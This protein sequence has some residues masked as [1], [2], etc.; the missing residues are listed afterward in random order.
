MTTVSNIFDGKKLLTI[1]DED[2]LRRSIE[3]F[4]EDMGFEVFGANNGRVGV[5]VFEQEHPDIVLVDLRMPEMGGLEVISFIMKISPLTPIIVVS[6]TGILDDAL[7]AIRAGAYDYVTKPVTDLK[8][9]E[10][11]VRKALEKTALAE[12]NRKYKEHLEE[13]VEKR[14]AELYHAQK[15]EAIGTLAGGIAHDFNNILSGVI[16]Y[17]ELAI[18]KSKEDEVVEFMH[19]IKK[20]LH[21]AKELVRQILTFS[22]KGE[23]EL[24]PL[25]IG[26]IV[27]E[28]IKLIHS[29]IPSSIS[30]KQHIDCKA[31]VL[32]DPSQ[33]H[34]I[35]MNLCTNA[36]HVM[37]KDGGE[38]SVSLT[39]TVILPNAMPDEQ[40][41]EPGSY[42]KL[43]VS[44]T[45]CG[46]D[47]ETQSK[48]FN[49]YFTTKPV[50]EGTGLGLSVVHGIVSSF[51]GLVTVH[52]ELGKGTTFFIYLPVEKAQ[53]TSAD[54]PQ[55]Q[56]VNLNGKECIIFVDDEEVITNLAVRAFSHFG[57]A[58]K[59]Y[60][61]PV[62]ALAAYKADPDACDMVLTDMTMPNMNGKE[63]AQSLLAIDPNLPIIL[64]SGFTEI[65]TK[66]EA[67]EMG[68]KGYLQKPMP[69]GDIIKEIRKIFDE[70]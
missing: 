28:A 65:L 2:G 11:I 35:I 61:D 6:G 42:I 68:I 10:H 40:Q 46:M 43:Q 54:K 3:I 53:K 63:L 31:S 12:E 41:I 16:G 38:L 55:T 62:D 26:L 34:Q 8:V 69:M 48:I 22:R 39:E 60:S 50:G 23:R 32:A 47:K 33:I 20:G 66:E 52:S 17:N 15:M 70:Q 18:E 5:E 44:D 4:F 45:G 21:R 25:Q 58:I 51:N 29:S 1:D 56:E 64:C 37:R 59:A 14:T 57:Y 9:L 19:E 13:L 36:Y 67:L 24:Q 30:L 49:P 27:R 7:E